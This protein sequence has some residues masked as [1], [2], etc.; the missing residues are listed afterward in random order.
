MVL[1]SL[2]TTSNGCWRTASLLPILIFRC[3]L[4][5][6]VLSDDVNPQS[7]ERSTVWAIKKFPNYLSLNKRKSLNHNAQEFSPVCLLTVTLYCNNYRLHSG[8]AQRCRID[9]SLAS[10]MAALVNFGKDLNK[11]DLILMGFI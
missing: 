7:W 5:N 4:Q 9:L 8:V 1:P 2:L 10:E 3:S 11:M 6:F